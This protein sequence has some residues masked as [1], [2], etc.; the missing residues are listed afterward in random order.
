[1]Y[2]LYGKDYVSYSSLKELLVSPLAFERYMTKKKEPTPAMNFGSAFDCKLFTPEE[3]DKR[4]FVFDPDDRPDPDKTFAAKVNKEWKAEQFAAA[5]IGKKT[6]LSLDE[7]GMLDQMIK[8]IK[9]TGVYDMYFR[10]TEVQKKL[11]G[12]IEGVPLL[13]YADSFSPML[14]RGADLKTFGES[15]DLF[16]TR[17]KFK[18]HYDLQAYVYTELLGIENFQFIVVTK[19][20]PFDV[21]VFDCSEDFIARGRDKFFRAVERLNF[22]FKEGAEVDLEAFVINDVLY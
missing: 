16:P 14:R 19:K 2:N 4:F 11:E 20:E 8:R 21:A 22:F 13:G 5:E 7:L 18:Y 6:T 15:I 1:M 10:G 9:E 3:F 12:E 17:A